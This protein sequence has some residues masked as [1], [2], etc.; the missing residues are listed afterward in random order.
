MTMT[1]GF[2]GKTDKRK[3]MV[4]GDQ[5]DPAS[6]RK[7]VLGHTSLLPPWD[8]QQSPCLAV[9]LWAVLEVPYL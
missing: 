7:E 1:Q 6:V 2:H 3:S 8:V 4:I 9:D 5:G